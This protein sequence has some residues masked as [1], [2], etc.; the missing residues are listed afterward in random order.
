[1]KI[2]SFDWLEVSEVERKLCCPICDATWVLEDESGINDISPCSHLRFFWINIV[3]EIQFFGD[4]NYDRFKKEYQKAYMEFYETD[5]LEDADLNSLD[6]EVLE[7][8]ESK[9]ID[10]VFD[11]TES[12]IAC[13][14]ITSTKLWGVKR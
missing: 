9:E 1:M 5:D 13:G 10:E 6:L 14:P 7:K 11:N 2:T 4:W 8:V 12:G 3:D